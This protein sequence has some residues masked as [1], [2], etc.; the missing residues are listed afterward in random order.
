MQLLDFYK[1]D[2]LNHT[3][4][5]EIN[6]TRPAFLEPVLL[7]AMPYADHHMFFPYFAVIALFG[8]AALSIRRLSGKPVNRAQGM[9]WAGLLL[10]LALG[11]VCVAGTVGMVKRFATVPRPYIAFPEQ[12]R[13]L[14]PKADPAKEL[15]SFPSGH[16]AFAAFMVAAL[17]PK[18]PLPFKA[19]GVAWVAFIAYGRV[20][21]GVHFPLDVTASVLF[22]VTLTVLLRHFTYKAL[23]APYSQ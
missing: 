15:F 13:V 23:R 8:L 16:A 1:E 19:L 11:Y 18:L 9:S 10:V 20:A 7:Q 21:V 14:G 3:L 2:S 4:A 22:A 5:V 6:R 17:W 12:I